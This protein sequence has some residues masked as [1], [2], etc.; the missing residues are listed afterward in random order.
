MEA[1]GAQ[2]LASNGFAAATV[3]YRLS[4]EAK[5]PSAI[6]D[7]K[8]AIRWI[9]ANAENYNIDSAKIAVYGC[10]AGGH[11]AAL[12]GS[13][14]G[15]KKFEGAGGNPSHSSDVQAVIDIDG[16]LNFTDPAESGKDLDSLKPSGGKLWLG[17]SYKENPSIWIEASPLTYAGPQNPPILF[18]NS[19][20]ARFHAGR[21]EFI[22]KLNKSG[23][24]SEVHTIPDTPHTFWL[25][26]PWFDQTAHHI[27]KFLNRIF[28]KK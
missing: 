24:Y 3:E 21:E 1:P 18:I 8:A 5:Y 12:I 25:F 27:I 11:L 16:V 13:T 20:N 17:Y 9:R 22:E 7:I 6:Y 2:H 19:S 26:H 28:I 15:I 4:P 14:N 10:S 23:I